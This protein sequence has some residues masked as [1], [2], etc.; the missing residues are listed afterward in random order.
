[1]YSVF[2]KR[3]FLVSLE[4]A[5]V[6][7]IRDTCLCIILFLCRHIPVLSTCNET[8]SLALNLT[9]W[10]LFLFSFNSATFS[11]NFCSLWE[12][13]ERQE[14]AASYLWRI[15]AEIKWAA[16]QRFSWAGGEAQA[17]LHRR[18]REAPKYL[19]RRSWEVQSA[20][21]GAGL[22]CLE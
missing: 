13:G 9:R 22:W 14:W 10:F 3:T 15:P 7:W 20:A 21:P 12:I 4:V 6:S 16:S 5:L 8:E 1:M 2:L 17:V 11:N 18:M 19:H